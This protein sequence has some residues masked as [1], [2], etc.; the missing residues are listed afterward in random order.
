MQNQV[1]DT[2]LLGKAI[3]P[4]QGFEHPDGSEITIHKDY[5]GRQRNL[6]N[7]SPGPFRLESQELLHLKVWPR[8]YN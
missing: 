8:E 3:I 4:D 1:I 2:E 7:P 5:F 6:E